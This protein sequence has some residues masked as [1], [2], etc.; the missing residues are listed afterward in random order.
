MVDAAVTL[1]RG[2]DIERDVTVV[3]IAN[4]FQEAHVAWDITCDCIT[5]RGHEP[6]LPSW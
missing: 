2:M 6:H 1:Q 4:H 3:T 5:S